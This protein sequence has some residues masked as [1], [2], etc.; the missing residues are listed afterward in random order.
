M[1]LD[2]KKVHKTI[3]DASAAKKQELYNEYF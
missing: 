2:G 1:T 3:A